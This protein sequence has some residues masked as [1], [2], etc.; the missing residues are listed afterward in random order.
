MNN[1]LFR[2]DA[3]DKIGLGHYKRCATLSKR[4]RNHTNIYYL[5]KSD[6]IVD[7]NKNKGYTTIKI[8]AESQLGQEIELTN[9][10]INNHMVDVIF[11]DIKHH[12]V[13]KNEN[14]YLNYLKKLHGLSPLL[15]LFEDLEINTKCADL[16]VIPYVGA[17]SLQLKDTSKYLLGSKYFVLRNE[18][19]SIPQVNKGSDV[20]SVLVSMGGA[21]VNKLTVKVVEVIIAISKKIHI[22]IVLG[23]ISR[24]KRK[25][26]MNLF[27][28]S[29]D[30]YE[31]FESPN[32][33]AQLMNESD[34]GVFSS[35]LTQYEASAMGL[36]MIII[37][38]NNYHRH[39]VDEFEK[40]KSCI[41]FGVF[42]EGRKLCLQKSIHNL[43][44]DKIVRYDM[45]NN[46]KKIVDGKGTDRII[47]NIQ[48]R[49]KVKYLKN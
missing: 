7:L 19:I 43:M 8:D 13:L 25:D 4:L 37:S 33:M 45:S 49:L 36:P 47:K 10:L 31:I 23:P 44:V 40:M 28:S 1:V 6:L 34:L 46:G 24:S 11:A 27:N 14:K 21:D 41:S 48:S 32:N 15:V 42:D 39:V 22:N 35:G 26:I 20:K 5:T 2:V 17:E 29:F 16:I 30:S 38:L 3:N 18:F 9:K 12:D